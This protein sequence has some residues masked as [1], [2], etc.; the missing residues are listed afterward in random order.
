MIPQAGAH[1]PSLHLILA[2]CIIIFT[3]SLH[4]DDHSGYRP[5]LGTF[6]IDILST[7]G[8]SENIIILHHR[9]YSIAWF[10]IN[11]FHLILLPAWW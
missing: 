3:H 10:R 4:L 11:L 2:F 7:G 9:Y 5:H 1:P 8:N 6:E